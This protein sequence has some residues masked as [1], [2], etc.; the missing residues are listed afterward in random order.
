MRK[1]KKTLS[2]LQRNSRTMLSG[3]PKWIFLFGFTSSAIQGKM[4]LDEPSSV[5]FS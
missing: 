4:S 3:F 5:N 2:I 1:R